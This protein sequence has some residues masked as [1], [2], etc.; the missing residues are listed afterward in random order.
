MEDGDRVLLIE[1]VVQ[2]DKGTSLSKFMDLAMLVMTG[3][4][5]RTEGE[6]WARLG[7]AGLRLTRIIPTPTEMSW[8]EAQRA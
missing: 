7:R 5:E 8:I 4:R 1:S 6:Y 3:G 2:P